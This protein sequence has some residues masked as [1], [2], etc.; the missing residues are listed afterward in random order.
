MRQRIRVMIDNDFSGDPDDLFQLAHHLLCPSVE[1]CGVIGSHLSPGDFL[2]PSGRSAEN[3]ANAARELIDLMGFS[4]SVPVYQGAPAALRDFRPVPT[5]ASAAI[6]RAAMDAVDSPLYVACGAGLTDFASALM[7]APEIADRVILVWIGGPEYPDLA[8]APPDCGGVEYNLAIDIAAA[9]HVFNRTRVPVWQV[10][11]DAYR[12]C[13]VSSAELEDAVLPCGPL[14]SY[15]CRS[16]DRVR[17]KM[18]GAGWADSETYVLGDQPLVLL[19]ALQTFFNPDAASCVSTCRD[20]L[21]IDENGSYGRVNAGRTIR[22]FRTIDTRLLFSDF[23]ARLR[24][25][26]RAAR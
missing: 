2:D 10:P 15:L 13:I 22:I 14:G 18:R 21:L 25:F 8:T 26:S 6:I 20:A 19:T 12:Q 9:M 16:L 11:R 24:K 1:I 17:E 7:E 23:F 3:A 5:E 4:G